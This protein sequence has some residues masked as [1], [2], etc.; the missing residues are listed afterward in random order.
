MANGQQ[1]AEQNVL[2]F[3]AWAA[4]MTD[5]G[6]RHII[7]RGKLNR[8]EVAKG[9]GCAKSVLLQNPIVCHLLAD[10]EDELRARG[11]LPASVVSRD[12]PE[13]LSYDQNT[14]I[15]KLKDKRLLSLEQEN[16]Q[17]KAEIDLLRAKISRYDELDQVLAE[18][19]KVPRWD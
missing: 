11:V 14:K 13:Q 10:L 16:I 3:Q 18:L 17:L 6:F 9:I 2:N 7:Y 4:S 8:G 15:D 19:G 5:Q 1:K 12:H